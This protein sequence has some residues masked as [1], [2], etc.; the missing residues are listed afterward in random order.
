MLGTIEG[1][2]LAWS[3]QGKFGENQT[4]IGRLQ[5]Y[6]IILILYESTYKDYFVVISKY[7]LCEVR[8]KYVKIC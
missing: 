3:A 7:G 6:D 4:S 8:N 1:S 2:C 5:D